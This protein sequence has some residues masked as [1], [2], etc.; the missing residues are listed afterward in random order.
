M[1][2][3]QAIELAKKYKAMVAERLPLKAL[4]L[5]GSYSKGNYRED[6]DIDIAV[7]VESLSD[8]YFDDTPL[9]W[10]LRRRIS[11]LIEPVLLT[12]DMDNP[13]YRDI[14]KTGILI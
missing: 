1:D 13:L 7:V 2:K 12:E 8:N 5:Y 4:Y 3:G 9:L 10:K 14:T 11:N 6:S